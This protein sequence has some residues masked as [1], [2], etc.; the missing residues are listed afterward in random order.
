MK[1]INKKLRGMNDM[2]DG[3]SPCNDFRQTQRTL[4]MQKTNLLSLQSQREEARKCYYTMR[5]FTG[6]LVKA[7]KESYTPICFLSVLCKIHYHHS[8]PTQIVNSDNGLTLAFNNS[9]L[10]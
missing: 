10:K 1:V 8:F 6:K 2:R 9:Q 4:K 7:T 3:G 5:L